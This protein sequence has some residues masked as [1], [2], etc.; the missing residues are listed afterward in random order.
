M[1]NKNAYGDEFGY[2]HTSTFSEDEFSSRMGTKV[3]DV[4]DTH[5]FDAT[6]EMASTF[7]NKL[8]SLKEKYPDYIKDIR[9]RGLMLAIEINPELLLVLK[10]NF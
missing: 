3:L 2:L 6:I 7:K 9:G 1:I 10:Q 8:I 4:L 5:D